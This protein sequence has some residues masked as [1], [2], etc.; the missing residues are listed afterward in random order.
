MNSSRLSYPH[1]FSLTGIIRLSNLESL[2]D[3]LATPPTIELS[4]SSILLATLVLIA[5]ILL[6]ARVVSSGRTPSV[7]CKECISRRR[8]G[9]NSEIAITAHAP[10]GDTQE[11]ELRV[12]KETN[13]PIG[14]WTS[15]RLFQAEKRAIFSK[16]I[17]QTRDIS[18]PLNLIKF[19]V[20]ALCD[21]QLSIQEA[22]R[23][24]FL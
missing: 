7:P 3:F 8:A 23:L 5:I 16:V 19:A 22:R 17:S 12:T 4:S 11:K 21:A 6:H 9:Q 1:H 14:W 2:I 15:E 18:K 20:V 10:V 24:L 13:F